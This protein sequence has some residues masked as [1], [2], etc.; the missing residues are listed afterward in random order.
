MHVENNKYNNKASSKYFYKAE[1]QSRG[2]KFPKH[3]VGNFLYMQKT[4]VSVKMKFQTDFF[5]QCKIL[6]GKH[7]FVSEPPEGLA[8]SLTWTE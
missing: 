7:C 1:S 8:S 5:N 6:Y 3:S 4:W 2:R